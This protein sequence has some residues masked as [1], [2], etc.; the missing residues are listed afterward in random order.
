MAET[1]PIFILD[2]SVILKWILFEEQCYEQAINV[3]E[4]IAQERI[5]AKV[6]AHCFIEVMN[7]LGHKA[8]KW[9]ITFLS[10]LQMSMIEECPM[11]LEAA[12]LVMKWIKE[13]P[14][15][16]FYDGLY[17]ALAFE[18]KGEFITADEVYF[19]RLKPEGRVMRLKDY[20]STP[21]S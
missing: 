8:P 3:R 20:R 15:I 17:H 1:K 16:S 13:Y 9:A 5:E 10:Q 14:R 12:S 19:N 7:T 4:D 18:Q 2:A 6:P 21:T 11:T